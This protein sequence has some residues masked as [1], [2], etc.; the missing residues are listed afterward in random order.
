MSPEQDTVASILNRPLTNK[1]VNEE[2]IKYVLDILSENP[3]ILVEIQ[4]TPDNLMSLI[5]KNQ[6]F[7]TEIFFK[8][9]KCVIFQE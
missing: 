9:S 4:F 7:A 5:E 1:S 6:Q 8:I 3:N 2:Q